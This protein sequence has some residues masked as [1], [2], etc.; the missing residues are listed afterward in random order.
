MLERCA[1]LIEPTLMQT[2]PS[3]WNM[4][5]ADMVHLGLMAWKFKKMGPEGAAAIE[6]LTGAARPILDRWFKSKN[7]KITLATD[8]VIG[9]M[10]A[11][12][13]PGTAYGRGRR[14]G[15]GGG[16]GRGGGGDGR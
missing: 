12:S 6:I 16:G 1:D 8:A 15:G 11:P 10:A 13:M 14:G 4:R 9:A 5:P 7:L 2:P 3:P